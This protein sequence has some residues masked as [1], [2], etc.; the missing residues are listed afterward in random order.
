MAETT[1]I[2]PIKRP[3]GPE[4]SVT[5]VSRGNLSVPDILNLIF[6]KKKWIHLNFY[7]RYLGKKQNKKRRK[8]H[9]FQAGIHGEEKKHIVLSMSSRNKAQPLSSWLW[10]LRFHVSR[11]EVKEKQ[12]PGSHD[13]RDSLI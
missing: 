2:S 8:R 3:S 10:E 11:W 5:F 7:L 6:A 13:R 9:L 12:H 4:I 1:H